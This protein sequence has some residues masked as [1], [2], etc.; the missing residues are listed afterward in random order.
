M[1]KSLGSK[2]KEMSEEHIATVTRLFG[3]FVEA[4][5]AS[6]LDVEGKEIR[7]Q[8]VTQGETPP[9]AREGGKV[10]LVP[11]SRVFSNE[12]FGYCTITVE[13]P[14]R[15]EQGEVVLGIKGKQKGKPQAGWG[16]TR[17]RERAAVGSGGIPTSC[18]RCC[19]MF[20]MRGSTKRRRRSATK[21]RST[22]TSMCSSR[23]A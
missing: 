12:A 3:G 14:L 21:S 18:A 1:R 10:K 16:A 17:Y 5:M 11:L 15:D 13:R 7:R 9:A 8:V 2:R 4:Q 23:R 20:P 6:V 19:P 22:G